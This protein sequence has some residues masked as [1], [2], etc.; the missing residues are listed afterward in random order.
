MFLVFNFIGVERS[1]FL[2]A[3][4]EYIKL[5]ISALQGLLFLIVENLRVQD[6][7]AEK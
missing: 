7:I 1:Y 3:Q 6:T 2:Q 4:Y 5:R